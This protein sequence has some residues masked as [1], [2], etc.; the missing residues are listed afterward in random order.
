MIVEVR[1][2]PAIGHEASKKRPCLIIQ[3]DVSN[4]N[5]PVTIV[6]AVMG[7]EH[8]VDFHPLHVAVPKGEGG[9][10]KDSVV[11]CNQIRSVDELRIGRTFGQ[12]R[13]ET[14]RRVDAALRVSL[15]L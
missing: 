12:L 10:L 8:F 7:A 1:L 14:M 6:A 11:K 5:S 15:E 9:L 13:A 4:R 2:D 3:N